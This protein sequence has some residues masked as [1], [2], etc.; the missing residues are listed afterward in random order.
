MVG[1]HYIISPDMVNLEPV[2]LS[3]QW[4][5]LYLCT[6]SC[7]Q[8]RIGGEKAQNT[9]NHVQRQII[10]VNSNDGACAV[11]IPADQQSFPNELS[12]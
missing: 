11:T 8:E 9:A 10:S 4:K 7:P 6:I 3:L 2:I 12:L 1:D 5:N